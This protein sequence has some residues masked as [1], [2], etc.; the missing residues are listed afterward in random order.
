MGDLPA[1]RVTPSSPFTHTGMDFAG[2]FSVKTYNL[3][4]ARTV[5]SYICIFVCFSTKA[6]HIESVHDLTSNSF[7]AALRRFTACRGCPT[8]L[9]S[10][11]G[12]NFVGADNALKK[13]ISQESNDLSEHALARGIKFHFN[14]PAAPFQGGLWERAVRSM[15]EHFKRIVG[16][17]KLQMDEFQ[18]VLCRIEAILNSRPLT[19]MSNDPNDLE[20]LTPGHF[21]I[22]RPVVS[23]PEEEHGD[24][25]LPRLKR[26]KYVEA[27]SQQLWKR[28][29]SEY[30]QT[31]QKRNKWLKTS[32]PLKEGDLVLIEDPQLP[33]LC[34]KRGRVLQT[35]P[36]KDGQVRV[37]TVRTPTGELKRPVLKL[38]RLPAED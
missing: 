26:W 34:W 23:P 12:T 11:C 18:T 3:R 15:K 28:W 5:Q 2:P 6:V 27:L 24:T 29:C 21:L 30:L 35:F 4:S 17:Q 13:L 32:T 20:V 19:P 16:D 7:I 36:G 37:A 1:P 8:D 31:L 14:P 33:T 10:D 38:F 9:Y 25:P 22:G